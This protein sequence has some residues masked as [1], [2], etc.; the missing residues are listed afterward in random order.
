M[1]HDLSIH[2]A[3]Q[4]TGLTPHTLRYYERVGLIDPICRAGSGYRRYAAHDIAWI[5][6]LTR[7]RATGMPIRTMQRFA[8]L[9]RGGESTLTERRLLLEEH[10]RSVTREVEELMLHLD[11]I[12][13]KI[14]T[15]TEL[16]KQ[17][18]GDERDDTVRA[19]TRQAGGS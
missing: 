3:A 13:G 4:F 12:A 17:H 14:Q 11:A 5:E 19:R 16:E 7:L 1:A 15:Y 6:F 2:D 10:K 9:R 8:E 18:D